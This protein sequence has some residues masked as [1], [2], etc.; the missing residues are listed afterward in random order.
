MTK[1][2]LRILKFVIAFS[3]SLR[4]PICLAIAALV[5]VGCDS[6]PGK[7][8]PAHRAIA[9]NAVVD[10]DA[11]YQRSCAGCH[12]QDGS[13]GPAPPLNDP[14]FLAIVSDAE[15]ERTV[16]EGR[17]GTSMPSFAEHRGGTLTDEQIKILAGGLKP[18]WQSQLANAAGL[19]PYAVTTGNASNGKQVF[20]AA[21]AGCHGAQGEGGDAGAINDVAFLSL[22]SDQALRRF[23]ITG[24]PDL[25]MPDYA[26]STQRDP[27]FQPLTSAQIDDLVSLLAAWRTGRVND[28]LTVQ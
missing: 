3:A 23:I 27:A 11:L 15:L 4:L 28:G 16:R 9:P 6:L 2:R 5:V 1:S 25:G 10:F 13:Q 17:A 20:A 21:C 22:I 7:P 18:K 8:D 24:R 26:D 14:L 12:G 19:P